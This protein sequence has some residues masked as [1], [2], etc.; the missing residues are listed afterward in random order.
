LPLYIDAE[1]AAPGGWPKGGA[2]ELK[3]PNRHLEYALT[4][5]GLAAALAAIF[6]MYA[7]GRL[8]RMTAP[9]G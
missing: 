4:W 1:A 2:T 6:V 5:F 9:G 8:R 3:L 7:S